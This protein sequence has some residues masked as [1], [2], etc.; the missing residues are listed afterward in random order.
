MSEQLYT[1]KDVE[2]DRV[3]PVFDAAQEFVAEGDILRHN[4]NR[5][6]TT[7]EEKDSEMQDLTVDGIGEAEL[8]LDMRLREFAQREPVDSVYSAIGHL[9][10][11]NSDNLAQT[12]AKIAELNKQNADKSAEVEAKI[13]E[14]RKRW[15]QRLTAELDNVQEISPNAVE[16]ARRLLISRT[17]AKFNPRILSPAVQ[18]LEDQQLLLMEAIEEETARLGSFATRSERLDALITRGGAAW[19]IPSAHHFKSEKGKERVQVELDELPVEPQLTEHGSR[20]LQAMRERHIDEPDASK[21]IALYLMENAGKTVSVRDLGNFLYT[22][23]VRAEISETGLRSRITT[24][25]G[26]AKNIVGRLLD[27]EGHVL[28]YGWRRVLEKSPDKIKIVGVQRIYRAI[29]MREAQALKPGTLKIEDESGT[30]RDEFVVVEQAET[31]DE[32]AAEAPEAPSP[33]T[34]KTRDTWI[35][36]FRQQIGTAINQLETLGLLTSRDSVPLRFVRTAYGNSGRVTD[37][38]LEKFVKADLLPQL[39]NVNPEIFGQQQISPTDLIILETFNTQKGP[40]RK[41]NRNRARAIELIN[42]ALDAYFSK[43]ESQ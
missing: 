18:S 11:V 24:L 9:M 21:Y 39:H 26:P 7:W 35:K 29:T 3:G 42:E 17:E 38:G 12:Q 37:T 23:E 2:P 6:R 43:K 8:Q 4:L 27:E 36:S 33:E 41:G 31:I 16:D 34:S 10:V 14:A 13:A 5:A 1:W 19:P 30:Y 15:E 40:L 32:P 22:D 28:Q 20:L 25:L